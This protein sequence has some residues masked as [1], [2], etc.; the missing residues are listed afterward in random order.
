MNVV[1]G[2]YFESCAFPA[3]AGLFGSGARAAMAVSALSPGTRLSTYA[4]AESAGDLRA[5][6][7]A[8]EVETDIVAIGE[9]LE[10]EYWHPLRKSWVP[11]A[12]RRYADLA[13][14]G[15]VVLGFGMLEG[16]ARL[17]AGRAVYD[18]RSADPASSFVRS[19]SRATEQLAYVVQDAD[20]VRLGPL[21]DPRDAATGV[22]AREGATL[23][24]SRHAFGGATVYRGDAPGIPVPAYAARRWFRIGAGDV[25]CAAF[26]HYWGERGLDAV[27]AADLA[28]RCVAWFNDGARLPLPPPDELEGMEAVPGRPASGC[29]VYLSGPRRTM[30]Q[31]WLF[32]E[33]AAYLD[34]LGFRTETAFAD[35]GPRSPTRANWPP[36]PRVPHSALLALGDVADLGT[37]LHVGYAQ[38]NGM[39][40]VLL[41][42]TASGGD[43]TMFSGSGCEVTH[44]LATA[45]YRTCMACLR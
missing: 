19:G 42:E 20:L 16:T 24:V 31:R 4:Y 11:E 30:A 6:M 21:P 23:V 22:M 17:T 7:A 18:P 5:T 26:A 44:D 25:F 41:A 36:R 45:L 32:D 13:V 9:R 37:N 3:W 34:A 28:S 12:G 8:F 15:D 38:A 2:T 14:T 29:R 33:A 10:F 40:V 43:L 39:P 35:D 27:G 1:G